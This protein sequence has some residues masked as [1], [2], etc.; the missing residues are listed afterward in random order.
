MLLSELLVHC[1]REMERRGLPGSSEA[2]FLVSHLTGVPRSRLFLEA[3]RE[4]G[5]PTVALRSLV[6]RRSSGEPLQYVLGEWDFHGR[7]FRLTHDTLIPRPETEGLVEEVLRAWR[8]EG[9]KGGRILD[10]GTGCGAIAVTIAAEAEASEV[11][12]VDLSRMALA[13]ARENAV[14][15]RVAERVRFLCADAYSALKSGHHFDVVV[16]N[17]PYVSEKEWESLPREVRGY[18]PAGA[19]LAGDDGLAVIRTLV[20]HAEEYLAPGGSLWLEIGESQGDAVRDLPCG[21]LRCLGVGKDLAGRDRIA[22]WIRPADRGR[23]GMPR[24]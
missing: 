8:M 9:R 19:L 18:E 15:H 11:V 7:P 4:V 17:P 20:G 12:A 10:V 21:S 13:V 3:G 23:A 5:N 16:S 1:R 14:R 6:S 24:E 22:R 2:E